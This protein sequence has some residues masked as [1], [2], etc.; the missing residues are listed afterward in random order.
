MVSKIGS[1]MRLQIRSRKKNALVTE[2]RTGSFAGHFSVRLWPRLHTGVWRVR[3]SLAAMMQDPI[4]SELDAYLHCARNIHT[5]VRA[6]FDE[7]D[8]G[9]RRA[10]L[11]PG[12]LD[13]LRP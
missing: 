3:F 8:L 1:A 7:L 10:R 2:C 12:E 11:A 4:G 9:V 13:H 5:L 6:R